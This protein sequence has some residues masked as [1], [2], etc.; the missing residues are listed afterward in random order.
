MKSAY[1]HICII[2]AGGTG[3]TAATF[4]ALAH[5]YPLVITAEAK[6]NTAYLRITGLIY[7][8]NNSAEEITR[9]IDEFLAQG[10]QDVEVY[11][12]GPGGDVFQAA[13]IENQIQRFPGSKKG[14]AGA[15]LASAYTKIASSLDECIQAENGQY[16]YHK[17]SGHL[18]GNEDAIASGLKLLQNMS[19]Q[20]KEAYSAKT[21]I[22]VD[23]IEANWS[24]GDV[25]LSAKEAAELKFISGVT[26]KAPITKETKA[27]FQACGSPTIPKI[28]NHTKPLKTMDQKIIALSLGL[29][30]DAS[31]ETIK[32]KIQANKLAAEEV[33]GLKAEKAAKENA[34]ATAKVDTLINDAI[35]EKKVNATQGESLKTWAKTDFAGCESYIKG[36][37]A[38]GKVS[39]AIVPGAAGAVKAFAEMTEIELQTMAQDDPEAFKAA[40]V[41]SLE[42]KK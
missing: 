26:K 6:D 25:W 13:E 5:D 22:S 8:W 24:K 4:S 34:D 27:L 35:A 16:M 36:L 23:V 31:E 28:T 14:T 37:T 7:E 2:G 11:L 40:Y 18:S 10:I 1:K 38:L 21:G 20:Y 19:I 29:P 15:L 41:A 9:K 33:A 3:L 32:A 39:A 12:N 17:P 30:E 42:V